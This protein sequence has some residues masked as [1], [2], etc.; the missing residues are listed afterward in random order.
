[1]RDDLSSPRLL[2]F[3]ITIAVSTALMGPFGTFTG[4]TIW[5]RAI[6]WPVVVLTSLLVGL[7]LQAL[8]RR[9]LAGAPRMLVTLAEG[10]MIGAIMTPLIVGFVQVAVDNDYAIRL[11][12]LETWAVSAIAYIMTA[13]SLHYS[14][15]HEATAA[16]RVPRRPR[17]Y[18]RLPDGT[19]ADVI[20]I[21]VEDHYVNVTLSDGA[22]HRL[23][24][25]LAD[26]VN[27]LDDVNGYCVHRSHWVLHGAIRSVFR[28]RGRDFIR[29]S[30]GEVIPV[31]KTYR[32]NLVK[33]GL[34]P[35]RA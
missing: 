32:P 12:P 25:R 13:T 27:E 3:S 35:E 16:A 34:L 26:A 29:I 1:M 22:R 5:E 24:L 2:G 8:S 19:S 28:E 31:S 11:T 21:T 20:H 6:F 7:F 17:L 4:M 33:A 15:H 10:V 14:E 9:W 30:N 23:L 18:A